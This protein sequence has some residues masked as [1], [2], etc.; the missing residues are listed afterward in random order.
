MPGSPKL[1][2]VT[3]F[4]SLARAKEGINAAMKVKV[5]VEKASPIRDI[6]WKVNRLTLSRPMN[7]LWW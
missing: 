7:K 6:C 2:A 3:G 5:K 4:A 1:L